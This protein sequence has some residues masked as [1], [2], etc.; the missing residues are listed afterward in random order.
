M[1]VCVYACLR[2]CARASVCALVRLCEWKRGRTVVS[3]NQQRF[4][5]GGRGAQSL[6]D[7][8]DQMLAQTHFVRR[9]YTHTQWD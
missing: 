7:T 4:I 6:V 5:P 1:C 8:L 2:F 9:V 3:D